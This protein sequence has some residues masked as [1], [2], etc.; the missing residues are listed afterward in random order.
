MQ[1]FPKLQS[2]NLSD[3]QPFGENRFGIYNTKT[4]Q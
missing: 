2:S 1:K 3:I 4:K